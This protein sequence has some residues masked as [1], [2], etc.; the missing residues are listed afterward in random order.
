MHKS[1]SYTELCETHSVSS[2]TS[3]DF[4][5]THFHHGPW[6]KAG[7]DHI[8]NGL[9]H[10]HMRAHV[11]SN[12]QLVLTPNITEAGRFTVYWL[13]TESALEINHV[14]FHI[15]THTQTQRTYWPLQH[16]YF[17]SGPCVLTLSLCS[18][19]QRQQE[20]I[21]PTVQIPFRHKSR[22]TIYSYWLLP[23]PGMR[24]DYSISFRLHLSS[25]FC[26]CGTSSSWQQGMQGTLDIPLPSLCW[27]IPRYPVH[28]KTCIIDPTGLGATK[29]Y[30]A[31]WLWVPGKS[32]ERHIEG[33]LWSEAQTT[34]TASFWISCSTQIHWPDSTQTG[35][36][37]SSL[38]QHINHFHCYTDE[39]VLCTTY[40]REGHMG[41]SHMYFLAM[42]WHQ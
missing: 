17:Q 30:F 23:L 3:T 7:S 31:Y 27:G 37:N 33:G 22:K 25:I 39:A 29:G 2:E 18:D 20:A 15:N 34:S 1:S 6:S 35:R 9:K 14:T 36:S 21:R 8:C 5:W 26:L 10:T 16:W 11:I 32:P 41:M 13:T 40:T 24:A 28:Q 12:L 19:L 38:T 42:N 4:V